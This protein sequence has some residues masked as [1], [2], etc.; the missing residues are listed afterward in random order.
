METM[1]C[2]ELFDRLSFLPFLPFSLFSFPT[3]LLP[4][5]SG[6]H[7]PPPIIQSDLPYSSLGGRLRRQYIGRMHA[8]VPNGALGRA[9]N[10]VR[11]DR[12]TYNLKHQPSFLIQESSSDPSTFP[13]DGGAHHH[14]ACAGW[15]TMSSSLKW[16][17][18]FAA[19]GGIL[20]GYDIGIISGT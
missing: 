19:L 17:A 6:T 3:V 4:N 13:A 1:T 11:A 2:V 5:R 9:P 14:G 15:S 7:H 18:V 10:I 20:F 16:A 8:A 12:H